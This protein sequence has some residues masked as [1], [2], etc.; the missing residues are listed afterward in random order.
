MQLNRAS[1]QRC[2]KR[3][4]D[5][6]VSIL[7]LLFLWPFFLIIALMIEVESEGPMI[8]KQKRV[9]KDGEVF[10]M[11][12]FRTMIKN[13]EELKEN[14]LRFN[15]ADGPVFKI[16]NDPRFTKVG[17]VL[18]RTGL[19]ELPQ[20]INVLKGEMS[21]IGPRPFPINEAKQIPSSY[22]KKRQALTPGMT[23]L[24][25][26]SGA[27]SLSFRKWMQLDHKYQRNISFK[28]DLVIFFTTVKMVVDA[29]LN[30]M[31]TDEN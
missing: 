6:V 10:L 25:V 1:Y 30:W 14:Y 5:L 24:W 22:K 17:K 11:Y 8:F 26:I 18:A 3:V 27:H 2:G 21:L 29:L 20:F 23:S 13:A 4:F 15:E 7:A 31:L 28:N 16:K 19:D 9:G 12:K